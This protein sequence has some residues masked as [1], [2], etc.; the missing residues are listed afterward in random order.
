M[1]DTLQSDET[2]SAASV[3]L[4]ALRPKPG[5]EIV[6]E[7]IQLA[8]QNYGALVLATLVPQL[9]VFGIDIW[10]FTHK[11]PLGLWL[12]YF[13]AVV[14]ASIANASAARVAMDAL[15]GRPPDLGRALRYV[16]RRAWPVVLSGLYRATFFILGL[17]ILL[18]P[19]LY[20]LSVYALIPV[21]PV[22]EPEV[23]SWQA[24]RRSASLTA[25]ARLLAFGVYVAP[26]VFVSGSVT[27]LTMFTARIMGPYGGPW[28]S[29]LLGS[30]LELT[31]RPFLAA[32]Q[33]RLYIELRMR[34][35]AIDIEWA[36]ASPSAAPVT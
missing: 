7:G 13:A 20:V 22:L 6:D 16:L 1:S 33:V 5:P 29:S 24:L 12:G 2:F 10:R 30:I 11:A 15:E 36:L 31:L 9:P 19:G 8:R 4:A 26:F 25:R 14:C 17:V 3:Q 27:A 18:I 32:I 21:L 28:F 35:E 23:G 34:K